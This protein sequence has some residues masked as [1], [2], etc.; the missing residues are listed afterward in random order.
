MKSTPKVGTTEQLSFTVE[1]K[2]T[3]EFAGDG[4]PAILS[5]PNL[6]GLIERTARHAIMP[7]LDEGERSVGVEIELRHLAATPLGKKVTCTARVIRAEGREISFHV[8]ASDEQ[9]IIARGSH[10]RRVIRVD[11]FAKRVAKKA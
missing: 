3:I 1:T 6:I 9:E 10:K 5:T 8:E 7:H 11:S 4:M 2:H